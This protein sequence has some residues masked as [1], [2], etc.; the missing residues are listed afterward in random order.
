MARGPLDDELGY[1]T[2]VSAAVPAVV[3]ALIDAE[4]EQQRVKW[5]EAGLL[6]RPPTRSDVVRKILMDWAGWKPGMAKRG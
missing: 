1:C 3:V 5:K 6:G 2:G 4:V